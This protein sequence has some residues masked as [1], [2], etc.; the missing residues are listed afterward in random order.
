MAL[1]FLGDELSAV[2]S[3]FCIT[4]EMKKKIKVDK[5]IGNPQDERS[6]DEGKVEV[7]EC[8]EI[9]GV[10]V[11]LRRFALLARGCRIS[12]SAQIADFPCS[13][14][15]KEPPPLVLTNVGCFALRF[16]HDFY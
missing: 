12:R 5:I 10:R 3:W 13:S 4:I 2:G 6:L 1:P 15:E 11:W 7:V 8:M 9:R 14:I 16:V